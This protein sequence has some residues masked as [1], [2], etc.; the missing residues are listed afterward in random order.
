MFDHY[1]LGRSYSR[2]EAAYYWGY[3]VLMNSFWIVIP[4][5]LLT[6]SVC[7]SGLAFSALHKAEKKLKS[8]G[9][10]GSAKKRI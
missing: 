4:L 3:F 10:N 2:P 8:N 5:F 7:A 6:K 9:Q 1:L